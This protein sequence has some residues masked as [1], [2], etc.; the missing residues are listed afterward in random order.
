MFLDPQSVIDH[1]KIGEGMKVADFGSGHGHWSVPVARR[2]GPYGRVYAVDVI[3]DSLQHLRS[4]AEGEGL[5]HIHFIQGNLENERG[6]MLSDQ[7]MDRVLLINTL[8]GVDD[9]LAVMKEAARVL[10]PKGYLALIDWKDSFNNIGPHQDHV[11]PLSE[12]L[13]TAFQ[14]GFDIQSEFD[15]GDMHYGFLFKLPSSS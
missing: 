5:S 4:E 3:S 9:K 14:S 15:A 6:S 8:F 10:R 1:F 13:D 12:A 7:S 11:L 2:V